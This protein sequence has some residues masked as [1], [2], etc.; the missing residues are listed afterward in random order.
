MHL[1]QSR[2]TNPIR[3]K[4]RHLLVFPSQEAYW[5]KHLVYTISMLHHTIQR[6]S[7]CTSTNG[8][9]VGPKGLSRSAPLRYGYGDPLG[10]LSSK[11]FPCLAITPNTIGFWNN[12]PR[13][14]SCGQFPARALF[15]SRSGGGNGSTGERTHAI[16]ELVSPSWVVLKLIAYSETVPFGH[17]PR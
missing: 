7:P 2:P 11:F 1:N 9:V 5:H 15:G 4:I 13:L 3:Y 14:D 16:L 8:G 10:Q 6:L 17:S 12:V